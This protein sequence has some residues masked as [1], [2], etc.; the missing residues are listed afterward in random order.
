[1][2]K[3]F[4][5]KIEDGMFQILQQPKRFRHKC[6]RIG[7]YSIDSQCVPQLIYFNYTD[8]KKVYLRGR[9]SSG[10]LQPCVIP[11]EFDVNELIRALE[12]YSKSNGWTF[13]H[14][15]TERVVL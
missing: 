9:R 15:K 5:V 10:D 12:E 8:V 1:M 13:I 11:E 2:T 6:C 3:I 14:N 4:N 7:D